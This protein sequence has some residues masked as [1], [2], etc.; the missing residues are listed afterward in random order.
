MRLPAGSAAFA[1]PPAREPLRADGGIHS[2]VVDLGQWV[3]LQLAEGQSD[4]RRLL[5]V[6]TVREMHALQFSSPVTA[7]PRN[8]YT[9]RFYG[10]GL[11]WQVLEQKSEKSLK[12]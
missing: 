11:G 6:K 2:T 10:T 9:A 12:Q 8:I 4:G 7:R 5:S 3:K 1:R